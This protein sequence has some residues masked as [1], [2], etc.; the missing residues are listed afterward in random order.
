MGRNGLPNLLPSLKTHTVMTFDF[1]EAVE[2]F[3]SQK[4]KQE[5]LEKLKMENKKVLKQLREQKRHL[6]EESEI[7]K[8][9]REV[10]LLR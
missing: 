4:E 10:K 1:Q 6:E 9:S 2:R 7:M 5:H 3:V 8:H